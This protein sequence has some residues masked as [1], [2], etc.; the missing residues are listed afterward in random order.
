MSLKNFFFNFEQETIDLFTPGKLAAILAGA[1]ILSFGMHNIHQQADI[2]E[3]GVL[4]LILLLNHWFGISPAIL[5]PVLDLLCY[6]FALRYLGK[7]FLKLSLVSTLSFAGFFHLWEQFPPVFPAFYTQPLAAALLGGILVGA[8]VGLVVRQGASCG[9]DDALALVIAKLTGCR[10]SR[11]YLAT[12]VT[13]LLL[14]LSY[15]PSQYIVY[16]LVTVTISSLLVEVVQNFGRSHRP[17]A[18]EAPARSTAA[19][20]PLKKISMV[21]PAKA[22]QASSKDDS[23]R[24][25]QARVNKPCRPNSTF[26]RSK[27]LIQKQIDDEK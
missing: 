4:G 27:G 7:D 23:A 18:A 13:V 15:I 5:A 6:A 22:A 8:G 14:S 9:G 12:D 1:A 26:P 10:I 3:G 21:A 17:K 2:T 11:A 24:K 19:N 20:Q 16:S 25:V